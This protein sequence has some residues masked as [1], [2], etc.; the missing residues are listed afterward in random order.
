MSSAI[1]NAVTL[2][3]ERAQRKG[4][5]LTMNVAA[6]AGVWSA[7]PRRFK[8]IVVN[9]LGNAVKFTP[10]GGSVAVRAGVDAAGLWVEV[11]DTGCGIAPEH[12]RLIFEK[13]SRVGGAVQYT[14]G[15]GLGLSLV[16]EL[17][18]LHGGEVSVRSA[19]GAGST[20]R[21]TI[22]AESR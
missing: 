20:F 12:Q 11:E 5:A 17:V 6:A 16:S 21:F 2:L 8:Q 3:R 22:P 10:A 14:E 13:F 18:R 7:D 19:L 9:L 15:T 1:A 4:L